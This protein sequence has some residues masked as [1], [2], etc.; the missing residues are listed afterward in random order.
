MTELDNNDCVFEK[1]SKRPRGLGFHG[2][3]REYQPLPVQV[4]GFL[5]WILRW[6]VLYVTVD[7]HPFHNILEIQRVVANLILIFRFNVR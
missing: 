1:S 7:G 6:I 5:Y 2:S 3:E 4:P